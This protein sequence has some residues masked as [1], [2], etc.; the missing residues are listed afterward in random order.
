MPAQ[1]AQQAIRP[2]TECEAP[3][4]GVCAVFHPIGRLPRVWRA[5]IP[6]SGLVAVM[7]DLG[8]GDLLSGGGWMSKNELDRFMAEP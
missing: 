3:G 6:P 2:H 8:H 5:R 1:Q 7:Q 4:V